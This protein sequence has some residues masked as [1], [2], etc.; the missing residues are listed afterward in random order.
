MNGHK[1]LAIVLKAMGHPVRLRILEAISFEGEACVCHLEHHLGERQAYISQQLAR[2]RGAGLVLDRREGLNIYYSL[3]DDAVATLLQEVK[4]AADAMSVS[5]ERPRAA[6]APIP[7]RSA[8][9]PCPR[10]QEKRQGVSASWS[11][12][13]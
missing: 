4:K 1:R 13:S 7:D 9:C 10:C 5:E 3:S 6:Y 2:M 11:K 12:A 8:T